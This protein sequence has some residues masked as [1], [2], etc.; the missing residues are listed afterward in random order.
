M[1][2]FSS[3]TQNQWSRTKPFGANVNIQA[4]QKMDGSEDWEE[5]CSV[6]SSLLSAPQLDGT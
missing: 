4:G 2:I 1:Y 5:R 6:V 3:E